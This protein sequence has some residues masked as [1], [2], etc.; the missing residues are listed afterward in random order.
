MLFLSKIKKKKRKEKLSRLFWSLPALLLHSHSSENPCPLT[1][2]S[3]PAFRMVSRHILSGK[4]V[5]T[6]PLQNCWT[7]NLSSLQ[8]SPTAWSSNCR[9]V[10]DGQ[11]HRCHPV[12][13]F[14]GTAHVSL[15]ASNTSNT[16]ILSPFFYA[17]PCSWS[18]LPFLLPTYANG[19]S[20]FHYTSWV[21]YT[22]YIT[23]QW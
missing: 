8:D 16:F 18:P 10:L 11:G 6:L 2:L 5:H 15:P 1:L 9:S 13:P 17:F 4:S 23:L 14:R 3:M 22:S 7:F 21:S 12:V 19:T 20:G